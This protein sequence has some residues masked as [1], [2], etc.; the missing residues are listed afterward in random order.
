L[1]E[2]LN[3]INELHATPT[4]T[5]IELVEHDPSSAA[6]ERSKA[7]FAP[8]GETLATPAAGADAVR[9]ARGALASPRSQQ[10]FD[11]SLGRV[12]KIIGCAP[13]SIPW[14]PLEKRVGSLCVSLSR[15]YRPATVAV[16]LSMVRAVYEKLW[17]QGAISQDRYARFLK[18]AKAPRGS[19]L[20]AGRALELGE[21]T[22]LQTWTAG[23]P[24]AR[25][26]LFRGLFAAL[27][28]AGLRAEEAAGA[29]VDAWQDDHVRIV[30]KGNK[31][32]TVPVGEGETAAVGAW[33]EARRA[34]KPRVPWLF[35]RINVIEGVQV[36]PHDVERL[37]EQ[38]I[39]RAC[40]EAARGTGLKHFTPHDLRRTFATQ[41][42]DAGVDLVTVQRLMG[43]EDPKTTARYDRRQAKD[44]A[45]AR[46]R[47][48]L[49]G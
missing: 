46:R 5:A 45:A 25:G 18:A 37:N 12:A 29:P 40:A 9:E 49:W 21:L 32:R 47:V 16:T 6:L 19:R 10:T 20:L 15:R 38:W 2:K 24:G 39:A 44:D 11:E 14:G 1:G 27:L 33:L 48:T 43:H 4:S 36:A 23:L 35:V 26:A 7:S 34:L 28:G 31:E 30:G 13:G 22:A 3:N 42:L 17:L 8:V 41:L